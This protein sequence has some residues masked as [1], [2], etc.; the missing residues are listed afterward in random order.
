MSPK[1]PTF[2]AIRVGL[3]NEREVARSV[4]GEGL[5]ESV[6]VDGSARKQRV[7]TVLIARRHVDGRWTSNIMCCFTECSKV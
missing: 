7:V 2:T 1:T 4:R 5:V 3:A 6:K